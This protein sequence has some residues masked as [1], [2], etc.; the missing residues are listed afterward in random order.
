VEINP[1]PTMLTASVT[2]IHLQGSASEVLLRLGKL[3]REPG[4]GPREH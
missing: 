4:S 3:L 1:E 2:D